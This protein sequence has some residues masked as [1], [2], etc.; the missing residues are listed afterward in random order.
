MLA[1]VQ[2]EQRPTVPDGHPDRIGGAPGR[3]GCQ[4]QGR[5]D[6]V[7]HLGVLPGR[8]EIDEPD[9]VDEL[10]AGP[11]GGLDRQPGLPAARGPDEGDQRVVAA[12]GEDLA[13]LLL[14]PDQRAVTAR[15]A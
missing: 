13:Q 4:A 3:G 6:R 14:P 7:D 8:G 10:V 2:H 9:A 12:Q 15:E 1:V 11:G 5:D